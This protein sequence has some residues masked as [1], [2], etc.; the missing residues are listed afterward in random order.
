MVQSILALMHLQREDLKQQ[1]QQQHHHH[2]QQQQQQPVLGLHEE[3]F[4][5]LHKHRPLGDRYLRHLH[6][7]PLHRGHLLLPLPLHFWTNLG[8]LPLTF[9]PLWSVYEELVLAL[10]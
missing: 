3:Q 10:V 5:R 7:V 2:Q 6:V 8:T 4:N 1:Q 9:S